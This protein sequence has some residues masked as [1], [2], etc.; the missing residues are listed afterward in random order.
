MKTVYVKP[1][2]V[3]R[4]V[5]LACYMT[6]VSATSLRGTY[7]TGQRFDK[8]NENGEIGLGNSIGVNNNDWDPQLWDL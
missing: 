5:N 4:S 7:N 2:I 8:E 3:V 6:Q 1:T